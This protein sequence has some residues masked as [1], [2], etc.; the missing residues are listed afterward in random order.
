M[1]TAK[2]VV[3]GPFG[4]GK[5][6]LIQ[7]ISEI[8]VLSTDRDISDHTREFKDKTTVAMDFGRITIDDDL[9]LY[10]FGTPGQE[11]FEFMWEILSE[12]MLGFVLLV[13]RSREESFEEA[14]DILEAFKSYGDVPYIIA[15][16]KHSGA[17]PAQEISYV[18][19]RMEIDDGVPIVPVDAMDVAS[20][21]NAILSLLY[22]VLENIDER[23]AQPA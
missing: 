2:I 6:T 5:T 21:K 4:A 19:N 18:A 22:S 7:T 16:N 11:R 14:F 1:I 23:V 17:D 15:V 12:G 10:L 20:V 8:A 9:I 3:T 13:D